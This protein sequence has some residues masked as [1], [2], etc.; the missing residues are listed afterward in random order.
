[1]KKIGMIVAIETDAIF[2]YY[3]YVE[4]LKSPS[5]YELF[6]HRGDNYK[7][8]FLHCGMGTVAAAAGTQ[9]LIDRCK[10]DL[11]VDFGVVGGLTDKMKVQKV[12]VVERIVHYRYDA[13]EF[14][15][16]KK[17]Q[18]PGKKDTFLHTDKNL[19]KKVLSL[20]KEIK[21]ATIASGDK[22]VS[23]AE[24]KA[25]IHK[26]F[27]CDICDMESAGIVLTC[28]ANDVPCLLLKAVSDGLMGGANEFWEELNRVSLIC[29]EITTEIIKELVK[30]EQ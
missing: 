30:E 24:E 29:L 4:R 5:G 27:K 14:M 28:E 15:D 16:L 10:V 17:G 18:L 22:F 7:I 13:S 8:Y 23:T 3:G 25:A 6:L 12:V 21:K 9:F 26:D 11:I 2:N 20:N 19:V 1:M